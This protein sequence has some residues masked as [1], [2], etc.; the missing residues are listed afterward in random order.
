MNRALSWNHVQPRQRSMMV[1]I[2]GGSLLLV[3]LI[4]VFASP[5]FRRYL[6]MER[7]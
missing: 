4:L 3:V 2:A 7:M 1:P 5:A 6:N